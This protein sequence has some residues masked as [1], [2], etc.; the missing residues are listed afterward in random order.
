VIWGWV[1]L[2]RG[3]LEFPALLLSLALPAIGA[4]WLGYFRLRIDD[5]G[6]QYR[7]L[8]GR[9]FNVAFSE[10][11]FLKSRVISYG[12]GFSYE[13]MLHLHDGRQLRLNLKPFPREVYGLLCQRISCDS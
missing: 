13:W 8:F 3:R 10:I 7:A 9:S 6:I 11:A 4:T 1:A 2:S 5:S 12:R